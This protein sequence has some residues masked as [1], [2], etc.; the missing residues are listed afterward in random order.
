MAY[1]YYEIKTYY[2]KKTKE[3]A[4]QMSARY[5][6]KGQGAWGTQKRMQEGDNKFLHLGLGSKLPGSLII[7][8]TNISFPPPLFF[9]PT[10]V[11]SQAC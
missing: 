6:D 10:K 2:E 7:F 9:F 11:K 3:N 8:M 4:P 5:W 1:K